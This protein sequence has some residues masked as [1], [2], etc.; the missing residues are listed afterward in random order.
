MKSSLRITFL[1]IT[2]AAV[3]ATFNLPIP[4]PVPGSI[5]GS[6]IAHIA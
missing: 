4:G 1:A 3:A 5:P 2:L 6:A